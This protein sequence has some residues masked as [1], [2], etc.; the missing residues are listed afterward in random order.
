VRSSTWG[1]ASI[2]T[3]ILVDDGQFRA[4]F[5]Q[6]PTPFP[7]AVAATAAWARER[8]GIRAAA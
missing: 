8:Y 6:G 1:D 5:G 3:R 2:S 7:E 4:A